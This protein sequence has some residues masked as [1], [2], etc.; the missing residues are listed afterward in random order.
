MNETLNIP[1]YAVEEG[2]D[3]ACWF[4]ENIDFEDFENKYRKA[5]LKEVKKNKIVYG[6]FCVD[7]LFQVVGTKNMRKDDV[8]QHN[9]GEYP[10]ITKKATDNGV[11]GFYDF[12]TEDGNVITISDIAPYCSYQEKPFISTSHVH[13]L[14]PKFQMT[15]YIAMYLITVLQ[16]EDFRYSYGRLFCQENIKKTVIKLP[17]KIDKNGQFEPDWNYMENYIK[18]LPYSS[19][20]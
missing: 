20:L 17:C 4:F 10:Y 7:R 5:V 2:Y 12:Y 3:K 9:Y 19:A 18:S 8:V 6:E 13:K 11:E 16:K 1:D 14:I 15:P